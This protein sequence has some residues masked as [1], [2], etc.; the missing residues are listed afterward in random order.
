MENTNPS[1]HTLVS[2]ITL[3][4]GDDASDRAQPHWAADAPRGGRAVL[5]RILKESATV[6][7][8]FA[9]TLVHSLRDVGY[10]TTTSALCEHIDNAIEAGA[11]TI[12]IYFR[13]TGRRGASTTDVM[14]YDNGSGMPPNVLKVAT[15]FGGSMSYGNRKGI[16][17]FG[18]G[19]KTA[20]LSMSPVMELYSW[21]EAS[22]FYNMTLDTDAIGR[23]KSNLV[24][25]PEPTFNSILP[26]PIIEMFTKPLGFPKDSSEQQ[27]LAAA[28]TNVYE[29]LGSHGTI[30]FMPDCDRLTYATDRKLVEHA[31]KESARVYRRFISKGLRLY[32]NNRLAEA[33]DPTYSMGSARHTRAEGL[34]VKTSRLVVPKTIQVPVNDGSKETAPVHI[35]LYALPIDDWSELPRKVLS[36]NLQ[37]FDG[38][39]VSIVRNDREVYAGYLTGVVERH[40]ENN[41]LR[42][43][44][45]FSGEL[46][47]A[48]GI[49]S[50]KQGVR[51]KSYLVDA[52][53]NAI[54]GDVTAVREE[55]RRVQSRR[56]TERAGSKPTPSEARA[57][58]ADAFQTEQ[59]NAPMSESE[60]A[61]VE[62]NLRGLAVALK[63]DGESDEVAYQRV[64][65]S[66]FLITHR[67]DPYWPFYHV[68]HKF[69][70]V[71]LTI[72]TAHPFFAHLYKPLLE[73]DI[74]EAVEGSAPTDQLVP[75]SKGPVLALELFLLSMARAQ[76]VLARESPE[77]AKLFESFRRSWS[78]T[79]RIQL[80]T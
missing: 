58:E 33:V 73:L 37:L 7:L 75:G 16:G 6:P 38:Q 62:A 18:M 32:I 53:A 23:D 17:R 65:S 13:Q 72:N 31:V 46:D 66:K 14:I 79:Y 61:Q 69:G 20:A 77:A 12:R 43:E 42:L 64:L 78:E 60:R 5:T 67:D 59:L 10:N 47:E 26:D 70:K 76:S 49:A 28:G 55:I 24:P 3:E 39:V 19:M 1:E 35:K 41:W 51:P 48:F 80:T 22:A 8:F 36:S 74:K 57:T 45:D 56:A 44:I 63:R 11:T 4:Y 29:E 30:V 9:Q 68:E 71:I 40:G 15:S 25:L 27:L 50:N 21:Q 34:N 54:G 2:D 52:I